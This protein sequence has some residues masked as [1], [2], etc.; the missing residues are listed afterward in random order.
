MSETTV[1]IGE[2][3]LTFNVDVDD[4]NQYL[5]E[6]MPNDKVAPAYNFLSRTVLDDCKEAM[7]KAVLTDG[8]PNGMLV[9]Q[10][11]GVLAGEFGG[12][13]E[14]SLKKPKKSAKA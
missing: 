14:V 6:Q 2:Q 4:F 8:K 13:V 1:T 11:A 10:I 5:N 12:G 9:L 7:K 3:D